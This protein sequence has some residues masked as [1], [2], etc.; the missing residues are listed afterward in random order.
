VLDVRRWAEIRRMREV[1]GLSIH[2]IARRTGNDRNTIRRA[3]RREGPPRYQ[4]APGPS[5]LDPFKDEIHRLLQADPNLPGKR[6]RELKRQNALDTE[7]RRLSFIPLPVV[8]EVGYI[9]FDP[10]AATSCSRWSP[11]ASNTGAPVEVTRQLIGLYPSAQL[12]DV[13]VLQPRSAIDGIL[14]S[15]ELGGF[16]ARG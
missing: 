7:L 3:L 16:R 2:E 8:D 15:F 13:L 12:A 10:E 11:P 5:K 4:R 6:L 9:P 14:K 1:E